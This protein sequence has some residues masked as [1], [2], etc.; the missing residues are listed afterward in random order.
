MHLPVILWIGVK[1][2]SL[3][4]DDGIK[5]ALEC[6]GILVKY[7]IYDVDCD[8]REA[9]TFPLTKLMKPSSY[10]L[11]VYLTGTLGV[12]IST[13]VYPDTKG[14]LGLYLNSQGKTYGVTA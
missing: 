3:S 4:R 7:S 11:Q 14:T 10:D 1:P 12:S 13:K 6:K 2:L 9:E 8:L 5:I